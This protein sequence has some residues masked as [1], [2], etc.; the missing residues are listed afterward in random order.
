LLTKLK[1]LHK[2]VSYIT[3]NPYFMAHTPQNVNE[4]F[5]SVYDLRENF[6]TKHGI[7]MNNINSVISQLTTDLTNKTVNTDTLNTV[8]TFL[9]NI[10]PSIDELKKLSKIIIEKINQNW[11]YIYKDGVKIAIRK[12]LAEKE[13]AVN[14]ADI[15]TEPML[16]KQ[17]IE[18][19][20]AEAIRNPI[21]IAGIVIG[22]LRLFRG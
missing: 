16:K 5:D 8:K 12:T 21:L 3:A 6:L 10:Q 9:V 17:I 11:T 19:A 14:N 1:T 13:T 22:V 2:T 20:K 18:N 4:V 15:I 7:V